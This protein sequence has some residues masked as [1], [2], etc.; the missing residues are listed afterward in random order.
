MSQQPC[1]KN[2]DIESML[3]S[4]Y[5]KLLLGWIHTKVNSRNA[6]VSPLCIQCVLWLLIDV[7]SCFFHDM[8]RI[9][10]YTTHLPFW[11]DE[12][13][14]GGLRTAWC[15]LQR[16]TSDSWRHSWVLALYLWGNGD[17]WRKISIHSFAAGRD[18][19]KKQ[20]RIG[21]MNYDFRFVLWIYWI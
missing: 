7:A 4:E 14:W 10:R 5:R 11:R 12:T 17:H 20:T 3:T 19:S 8:Q 2:H 16:Y 13:Y 6:T 1:T 9:R 18:G 21:E 15:P